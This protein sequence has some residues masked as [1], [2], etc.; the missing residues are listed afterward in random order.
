M[1][2]SQN[3]YDQGT[4]NLITQARL[5]E[6]KQKLEQDKLQK[7]YIDK[8]AVEHPE[9]GAFARAFLVQQMLLASLYSQINQK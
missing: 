2:Q 8:F 4:Q 7:E 1:T 5:S 9:Q 6:L 3:A